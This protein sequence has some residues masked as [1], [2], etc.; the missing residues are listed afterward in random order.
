VTIVSLDLFRDVRDPEPKV[1]VSGSIKTDV[2]KAETIDETPTVQMKNIKSAL[3][4]FLRV[5]QGTCSTDSDFTA[6][7]SLTSRWGESVD[8]SGSTSSV[9]AFQCDPEDN[10]QADDRSGDV[11]ADDRSGVY[12]S[13]V[14]VRTFVRVHH[15]HLVVYSRRIIVQH[16]L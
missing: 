12:F 7:L 6:E 1:E 5:E 13:E 8:F 14:T 16:V 3:T 11:Q 10:A 2:P 15:H 4:T 9:N